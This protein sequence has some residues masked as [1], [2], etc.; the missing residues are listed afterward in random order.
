[1]VLKG[2]PNLD[3]GYNIYIAP[4]ASTEGDARDPIPNIHVIDIVSAKKRS[5]KTISMS[6]ER[7]TIP[8]AQYIISAILTD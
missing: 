1:M 4:G 5:I 6:D 8:R 2:A 3:V 7:Q